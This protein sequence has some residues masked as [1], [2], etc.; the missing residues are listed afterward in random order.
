MPV[1]QGTGKGIQEIQAGAR[2]TGIVQPD[3]GADGIGCL[4]LI[5]RIDTDR[6]PRP[7]R[8]L[9]SPMT[10]FSCIPASPLHDLSAIENVP[11]ERLAMIDEHVARL[12]PGSL[13]DAMRQRCQQLS[14]GCFCYEIRAE[15]VDHNRVGV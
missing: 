6:G 11:A 7:L 1:F 14:E 12:Y 5:P 3:E 9:S 10:A 2:A 13:R 15:Q 4:Q 8:A